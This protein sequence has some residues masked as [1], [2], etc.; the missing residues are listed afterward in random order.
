MR[1]LM[2][3]MAVAAV[4]FCAMCQSEP[5]SATPIQWRVEDGGNGHWYALTQ[6]YGTWEECDNEAVAAG[7]Y[8]ADITDASENAWLTEFIRGSVDRGQSPDHNCAWIGL[9]LQ[10]GDPTSPSSWVW[11]SGAPV[12]YWNPYLSKPSNEPYGT[13]MYL[14][15]PDQLIGPGQWNDNPRH[16][17][18]YDLNP[19]GII[20]FVPEPSTLILLGIGAISLTAYGWRRRAK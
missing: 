19:R 2:I 13:Y 5:V 1:R 6:N 8:L 4:C 18:E 16:E 9:S 14:H 7:G 10:G 11:Q 15:G 20:E 3:G 17:D 12:T